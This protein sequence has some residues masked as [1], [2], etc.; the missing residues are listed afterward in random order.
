MKSQEITNVT[1]VIPKDKCRVCGSFQG[2]PCGFYLF[3][4]FFL[5]KS[6]EATNLM[7]A[8]W[9]KSC[10]EQ[11]HWASASEDHEHLYSI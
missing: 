6:S 7:A 8:L 11:S 5:N 3:F 10:V 1:K 9:E 4:Y 2:T